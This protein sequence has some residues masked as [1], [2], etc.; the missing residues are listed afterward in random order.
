MQNKVDQTLGALTD[1][2]DQKR[3]DRVKAANDYREDQVEALQ[4]LIYELRRGL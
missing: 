2:V 3:K 1:G 4:D